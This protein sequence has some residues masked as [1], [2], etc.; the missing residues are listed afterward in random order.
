ME[1]EKIKQDVNNQIEEIA[2]KLGSMENVIDEMQQK[3]ANILTDDFCKRLD[4]CP[5][6]HPKNIC[7]TF[8]KDIICVKNNCRERH[9]NSCRYF[10]REVCWR[11][12][13]CMYI[14]KLTKKVTADFIEFFYL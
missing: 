6:Y 2:N 9:P 10:Q 14:H 3:C 12:V 8:K 1:E 5:Y 7:E 13:S 11:G 4:S